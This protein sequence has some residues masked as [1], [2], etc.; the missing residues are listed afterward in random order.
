MVM[1]QIGHN[2]NF[3]GKKSQQSWEGEGRNGGGRLLKAF[4]CRTLGGTLIQM[5]L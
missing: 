2:I 3:I 5:Y 1:V 4:P